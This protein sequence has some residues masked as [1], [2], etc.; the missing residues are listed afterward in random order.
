M[1]MYICLHTLIHIRTQTELLHA[2]GEDFIVTCIMSCFL[3]AGLCAHVYMFVR[4]DRKAP[5]WYCKLLVC[6]C[7]FACMCECR[8][9]GGMHVCMLM[10][11]DTWQTDR[12]CVLYVHAHIHTHTCSRCIVVALA[13]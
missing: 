12:H 3:S 11:H 10:K 5:L 2:D 1:Y 13:C 6:I 7:M 8:H 4:A 9:E